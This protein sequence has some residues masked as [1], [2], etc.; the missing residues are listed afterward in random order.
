M[1]FEGVWK[2]AIATPIGEQLVD[3]RIR[4]HNGAF[5][6]TAT[7]GEET[8]EMVDPVIEGDRI[9]WSQQISRPM[10]LKIKFSLT[11]DGDTLSG[12]AKPGILPSTAVTGTRQ[13]D[14]QL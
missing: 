7:Q 4:E 5:S 12:S 11:R 2:I 13:P 1:S 10:K 8:V 9:Q 3:L 6:G 14:V